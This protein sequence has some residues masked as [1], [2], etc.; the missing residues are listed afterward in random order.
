MNK[1]Q[2]SAIEQRSIALAAIAQ[3]AFCVNEIAE[4]GQ[5]D[6]AETNV[7]LNSIYSLD[8]EDI[9][10]IY[11]PAEL[12]RGLQELTLIFND[13]PQQIYH[14]SMISI[15]IS[16]LHAAKIL[17]KKVPVKNALR[18]QLQ[19]HIARR[20][21]RQD[22]TISKKELAD[23]YV[24]TLGSFQFRIQIHG[25][26]EHLKEDNN[27]HAIRATLLAGVRAALLWQQLGGSRW[28]LIFKRKQIIKTIQSLLERYS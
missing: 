13:T 12:K 25:K 8:P 21:L 15:M 27:V 5:T 10:D 14:K 28:Q 16:L 18:Q 11:D 24:D 6:Q 4:N 7:L 9:Y 1:P 22:D 17:N 2:L 19:S 20:D 3:S 23:T 26:P